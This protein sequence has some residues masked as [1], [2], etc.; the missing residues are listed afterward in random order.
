VQGRANQIKKQVVLALIVALSPATIM[1]GGVPDESDTT[2]EIRI[3]PD[4]GEGFGDGFYVGGALG[5]SFGG[6]D[7]VGLQN[8][9]APILTFGILENSGG[10]WSLFTGWRQD[11]G[12]F[13]WGFEL[14]Y[15]AGSVDSTVVGSGYSARMELN[16]ATTLRLVG[17]IPVFQRTELYG[18][19]GL[20]YGEFDYRVDGTGMVGP[21]A[22]DSNLTEWG[23]ALGL[24]LEQELN[25]NWSVRLEYQYMNFGSIR[26]QDAWGAETVATPD[27]GSVQFGVSYS[28]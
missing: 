20:A 26:L 24:G 15:I 7:R 21:V 10:T 22:I 9:L 27:F 5:Y 4:T 6:D 17:S 16:S 3:S 28:F 2:R 25:E 23:Y 12:A 1:A 18:F 13:G 11:L 8:R 19:G 14:N